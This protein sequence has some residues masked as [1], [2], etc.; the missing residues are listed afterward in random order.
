LIKHRH[1]RGDVLDLNSEVCKDSFLNNSKIAEQ[2][3][4]YSSTL[5]DSWVEYSDIVRS[6][7]TGGDIKN[8][9]LIMSVVGRSSLDGVRAYDSTIYD[10]DLANVNIRGGSIKGCIIRSDVWIGNAELIGLHIDKPMRIGTGTWTR[11]PR[12]LELNDEI[13]Q[14]VIVTES[15]DGHAYVGCCRKPIDRWLKGA[16]RFQRVMGWTDETAGLIC[17]TFEEWLDN[18]L[19]N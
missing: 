4:V 9:R 12:T 5:K 6:Y 15:T 10:S 1:T 19:P 14:N 18:P 17:R 8:S 16:K 11:V 2:S 13:V 7:V 3:D